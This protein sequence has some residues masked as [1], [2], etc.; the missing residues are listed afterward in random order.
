M[1]DKLAAW[2]ICNAHSH[3]SGDAALGT[4]VSSRSRHA[5]P[6]PFRSGP[7]DAH[8]RHPCQ[9]ARSALTSMPMLR[10]RGRP[11]CPLDRSHRDLQL[12][13]SERELPEQLRW[14]RWDPL[15]P[16]RPPGGYQPSPCYVQ[17]SPTARGGS[18]LV[19]WLDG[20]EEAEAPSAGPR[21]HQGAG[22]Q[23]QKNLVGFGCSV[24]VSTCRCRSK[25]VAGD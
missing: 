6:L 14:L 20:Q 23:V 17:N 24:G 8:H 22:V 15:P 1:L 7:C 25:A 21:H 18:S 5:G 4:D 12:L 9:A 11:I 13:P 10:S 16:A 3:D 19:L 2:P